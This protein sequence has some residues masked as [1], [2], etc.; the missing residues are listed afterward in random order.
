MS[1][2]DPSANPG[3]SLIAT[4]K[5]STGTTM[6]NSYDIIYPTNAPVA[7]G[8]NTATCPVFTSGQPFALPVYTTAALAAQA[9]LSS[10]GPAGTDPGPHGGLRPLTDPFALAQKL[11]LRNLAY[12]PVA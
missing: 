5:A 6:Y 2:F 12:S 9:M 1:L 11:A 7:P 3:D 4:T 8:V 10:S